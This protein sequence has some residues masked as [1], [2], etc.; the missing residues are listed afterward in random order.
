MPDFDSKVQ[1]SYEEALEATKKLI[2]ESVSRRLISERPLGSFLSG[3]Y[4]STVVT[5]YMAK[6]M[7]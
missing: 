4:D 7:N 3:G 6:L 2:E 1:I 5:A